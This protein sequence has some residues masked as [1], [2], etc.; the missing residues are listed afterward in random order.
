MPAE[1]RVLVTRPEG[2][3]QPLIDGL[4]A[5]GLQA[6]HLPMLRLVPVEPLPAA[7]KQRVLDLERYQHLIFIS[8]NAVRFGLATIDDFWHQYPQGQRVWAVGGSTAAALR[9]A[10]LPAVTPQDTLS[11]EGLLAMSGLQDVEGER[12]LIIKGEGGRD[13]LQRELAARGAEVHTLC[14]YRREAPALDGAACR[15]MLQAS[16]VQLILI[17][18]GEGLAQLSRLLQPMENTNLA[19]LPVIVP[20]AR[21]LD[22]GAALGWRVLR[23]A[24]NASD[25]AMLEAV[26]AWQLDRS[27][28]RPR[29]ERL[30]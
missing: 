7:A 26:A 14:C 3:A 30:H 6:L 18:S 5:M 20:S 4:E 19:G 25:A 27:A 8:A 21:V 17:S 11:S 28:R 29:G 23:L 15:A 13:L 10:G 2:Q 24:R 22:E 16:P 1:Q 9:S 12:V